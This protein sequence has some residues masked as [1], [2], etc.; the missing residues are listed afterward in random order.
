MYGEEVTAKQISDLE[1]F[2]DRLLDK[3]GVDI[4]FSKHFADR[5]NDDRNKPEIKVA[6]IQALFKKIARKKAVNIK[7][8]KN[9]EVVLKDI[10]KDLNLPVAIKTG[11]DG[12]L[13]VVHKTIMRKKNFKTPNPVVQYEETQLDEGVNDPAIF[14]AVFLAGGPGSGKGFVGQGLF[15]IPKKVNVS[16]FGLKLVNQD[17]ELVRMLNKYGFGTDLDDM[18]E[19]L[20]RQLTD[21][22]YEDYSGLRGRAKELTRDR[23]K[24]YMEGRLGMIIDGTGH[25]FDKIRKRKQELEE[26]GYDCFMVFVH[27]DLEVAQ[28]RNMERPRKLNPELVEES[29]NDVQKN[30]IY[31]QGLFG[32]ANFMMVDNSNTLS[33][34]QATKKFNM[35]VKKGIGSFIKKPVK[36]YRGKKWVERQLILK[37]IK[38]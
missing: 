15:G 12:E 14:K 32:N 30:K 22:D 25:K 35:L 10:Q 4:E 29:W 2:G 11:K 28:K 38:W 6:E 27:T 33:E 36:N 17:K 23:Q 26:I 31:F 19:E 8:H 1:K 5:M 3:F 37:G 21:P 7:K 9:S 18:P 13:D 20:F 16:A 24:L 34:K